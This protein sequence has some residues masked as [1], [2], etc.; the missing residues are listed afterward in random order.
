M[1]L[2]GARPCIIFAVVVEQLHETILMQLH[3]GW[4][5]F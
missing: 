3:A 2:V 4:M 1:V 5:L